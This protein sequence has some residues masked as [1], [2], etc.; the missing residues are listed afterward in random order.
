VA[1]MSNPMSMPIEALLNEIAA[2]DPRIIELAVERIRS[3]S[4]AAELA[5]L[6]ET[7]P[8]PDLGLD[9]DES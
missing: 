3:R 8:L 6:R 9:D 2:I 4:L 5:T 7:V 1:E